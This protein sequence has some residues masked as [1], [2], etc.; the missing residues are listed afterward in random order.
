MRFF[1]TTIGIDVG[2]SS[3]KIIE[4]SRFGKRVNLKNY[5]ELQ[6]AE[7]NS[8]PFRAF[9]SETLF[10]A[11]EETAQVIRFSFQESGIKKTRAVLTLPDFLTFFATLNFP[12]MGREELEQAVRFEA[13]KVIPAPLAE[14]L[15]DWNVIQGVPG[16][17]QPLAVLVVAIPKV[18]TSQYNEL[19]RQI[20]LSNYT[21]EPEAFSLLRTF[22]RNEDKKICLVD[23][24]MQSTTITIG[25][26]GKFLTSHSLNIAGED[27]TKELVKSLNIT[28]QEAESLKRKEGMASKTKEACR[29]FETEA[30]KL[31]KAIQ[32]VIGSTLSTN[33]HSRKISKIILTGGGAKMPGLVDHLNMQVKVKTE[34]GQPFRGIGYPSI[35]RPELEEIGPF[36]GVALGA[37]LRNF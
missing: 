28:Y 1:K 6:S 24:G 22:S 30:D 36:F 21:L 27:T 10:L 23:I 20:P 26:A 16:K 14:M 37:A 19:A 17:N 15:L 31:S 8:K 2:G 34:L 9:R 5:A 29:I 25:E 33:N 18:I 12:S 3:I 4:L 32:E 13:I 11:E 7:V 35:L